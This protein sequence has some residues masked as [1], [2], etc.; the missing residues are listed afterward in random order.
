MSTAAPKRRRRWLRAR[1]WHHWLGAVFALPLLWVT[2]SGLLLNRADDLGLNRKLV[3][4]G[5]LLEHYGMLPEGEARGVAAGTRRVAGWDGL[6]FLDESLL[7]EEGVLVGAVAAGPDLV[8][9]TS[10][11]LYVYAPQGELADVLGEASLPAFPVERVGNTADGGLVVEAGGSSWR[12][13]EDYLSFGEVPAGEV[14]WSVPVPVE[15]GPLESSLAEG[16]R[17]PWSRVVL[18]LHSGNWFGPA[19]RLLVD[20]TGLGVIVMT[21]FGIKLVFKR[22][23]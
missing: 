20:L 2:A 13:S 21:L 4:S 14:R 12:A 5:N 7:E 1:S 15:S 6:L 16:A 22:I 9:G 10:D 18:D 23:R 11:S 17:I 3:R 19:G 8:V